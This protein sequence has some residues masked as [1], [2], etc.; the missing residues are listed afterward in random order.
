MPD[1]KSRGPVYRR[2]P[3]ATIFYLFINRNSAMIAARL[4]VIDRGCTQD[5]YSA[6][7]FGK[8]KTMPISCFKMSAAII[9]M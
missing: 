9:E 3:L 1:S 7:C 4:V 8:T 5:A 6:I 2:R